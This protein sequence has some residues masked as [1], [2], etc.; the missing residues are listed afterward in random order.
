MRV[1]TGDVG[2]ANFNRGGNI[3]DSRKE[4]MVR[5]GCY[6]FLLWF[7]LALD[8]VKADEVKVFAD[9]PLQYSLVRIGA[10]FQ[11]ETSH[12]V[13]FVFASSPAIDGRLRK[14]EPADVIVVQPNFI[15]ALTKDGQL[16]ASDRPTVTRVGFGL[17]IRTQVPAEAVSDPE[18]L[19]Q[20]LL[21]ADSVVCNNRASGDHFVTIIDRLG[22]TD[23][24]KPKISRVEPSEV[25]AKI[26]RGQGYDIAVG[27]LTQIKGTPGLRLIGP[28]PGELQ[29]YITYSIAQ[30]KNTKSKDAAEAFIRFV[31]SPKA[32]VEFASAG[33]E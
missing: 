24:I 2:L 22:M 16:V 13:E 3:P 5:M 30:T 4:N 15:A 23:A 10:A 20:T 1:P 12:K 19:K 18:T 28:L 11:Q 26:L 29:S 7:S 33:G 6:A 25:F 9:E 27:T 31:M 32:K 14:G 17:A 21:K 8:A